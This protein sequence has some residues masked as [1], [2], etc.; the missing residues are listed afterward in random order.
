M[1]KVHSGIQHQVETKHLDTIRNLLLSTRCDLD[2]VQSST[3]VALDA[4]YV[5]HQCG[6]PHLVDNGRKWRVLANSPQPGNAN[7]TVTFDHHST[8]K[9]TFAFLG[10]RAVC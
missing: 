7:T 4:A 9:V 3:H 1:L 10:L 6:R 8:P 2:Q 5:A